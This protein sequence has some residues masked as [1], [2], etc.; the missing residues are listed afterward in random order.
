MNRSCIPEY[1]Y[2]ERIEKA[3]KLAKERKLD[4]LVINGS[5]ADYANTR[6]FSGFWPVFERV[7]VAITPSGDCA[8]MVGPESEIF[9]GDFGR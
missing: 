8:L 5:E 6:Y 3:A 1:E 9:A 7:G 2:K 4:I